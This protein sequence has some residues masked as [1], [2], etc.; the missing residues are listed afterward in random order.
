LYTQG[1]FFYYG[2]HFLFSKILSR[3]FDINH[4]NLVS[5]SVIQLYI[6]TEGMYS[7][8]VLS[9]ELT[10]DVEMTSLYYY[11]LDLSGI[12]RNKVS[13]QASAIRAS[14]PYYGPNSG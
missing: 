3:P 4:F 1:Y 13:G 14:K 2:Y 12:D 5:E 8:V 11:Q 7:L 6:G 10:L 9:L